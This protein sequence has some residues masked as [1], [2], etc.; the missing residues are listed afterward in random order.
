MGKRAFSIADGGSIRDV[1]LWG[2]EFK[3]FWGEACPKCASTNTV[4]CEVGSVVCARSCTKIYC[5]ACK[6][7]KSWILM[8]R[9]RGEKS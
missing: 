9:S 7:E 2:S 1:E 8:D 4:R 3:Y 5:G 6:T